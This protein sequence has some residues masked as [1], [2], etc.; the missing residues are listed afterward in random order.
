MVALWCTVTAKRSDSTGGNGPRRSDRVM[1]MANGGV[2]WPKNGG[3]DGGHGPVK[4][5]AV[6]E[7]APMQMCRG[8]C[9]KALT[10]LVAKG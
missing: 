4:G 10:K 3:S 6:G 2:G 7:G 1:C 5:V 9:A 8:G